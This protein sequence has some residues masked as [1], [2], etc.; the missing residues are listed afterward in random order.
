MP[1]RANR[2]LPCTGE[3]RRGKDAG[4]MLYN[5]MTD[6]GIGI[7]FSTR[8]FAVANK[9]KKQTKQKDRT[10]ERVL[11]KYA[12]VAEYQVEKGEKTGPLAT[13]GKLR[14][15]RDRPHGEQTCVVARDSRI[16]M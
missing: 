16:V 14:F 11:R 4:E 3:R 10:Y 8:P 13:R 6:D 15:C 1:G 12:E 9:N 7:P 5:G 2:R